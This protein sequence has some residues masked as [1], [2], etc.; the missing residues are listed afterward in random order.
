MPIG[1][2]HK[3]ALTEVRAWKKMEGQSC[4]SW[5]ADFHFLLPPVLLSVG[6]VCS[7]WDTGT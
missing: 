1:L 4:L 5:L 3:K 7:R 6:G 2:T